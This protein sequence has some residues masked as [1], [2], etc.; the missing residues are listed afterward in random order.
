VNHLPADDPLRAAP[1]AVQV[2][3]DADEAR[4]YRQT[5]RGK[6]ALPPTK[7]GSGQ[8][9]AP[10]AAETSA[11]MADVKS[12]SAE[13]SPPDGVLTGSGTPVTMPT[14]VGQPMRDVVVAAAN[15]GLNVRVYGDGIAAAQAPAP[16]TR[17]PAG[18]T[19]VVRFHP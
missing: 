19:V 2:S 10:R 4:A 16:G 18:T 6:D 3:A 11:T 9:A 8:E 12:A 5:V 7:N 15:L 17:V 13:K 14:F 1:Q